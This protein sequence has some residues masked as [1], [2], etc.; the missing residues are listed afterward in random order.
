MIVPTAT[1]RFRWF[2]IP[3]AWLTS[4]NSAL[5][6]YVGHVNQ[7]EWYGWGPAELLYLG[8]RVLRRYTPP[9]PARERWGGD[10]YSTAKLCDVELIF[11]ETVRESPR[12]VPTPSNP[13]YLAAGHNLEY[14]LHDRQPYYIVP[15]RVRTA[16]P[17]PETPL[18]FS[19]PFQL[20][21]TD[22]DSWSA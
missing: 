20:F 15:G 8:S 21:F 14:W 9:V 5:V 7:H 10:S 2:Q 6:Q 3:F 17:K 4:Y 16:D 22:P 18:Y 13:N 12:P 1:V 11:E 19:F